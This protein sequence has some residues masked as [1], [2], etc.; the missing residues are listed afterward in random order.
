MS[1]FS[2]LK[3]LFTE[4]INKEEIEQM[5]E[6]ELKKELVNTDY[7]LKMFD[8]KHKDELS[9][10]TSFIVQ[11]K[12]IALIKMNKFTGD[13]AALKETL[14]ELKQTCDTCN[15]RVLGINNNMFLVVK[16]S[17]EVLKE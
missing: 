4:D 11:D 15:S 12:S 16:N 8:L 13:H 9:N 6:E 5:Q 14:N 10:I 7:K 2:W 1:L 3:N 17:V